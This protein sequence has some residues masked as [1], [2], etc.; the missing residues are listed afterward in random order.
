[1]RFGEVRPTPVRSA[2]RPHNN[3]QGTGA[4]DCL[5]FSRRSFACEPYAVARFPRSSLVLL[6]SP[7]SPGQQ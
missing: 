3:T 5:L 6:L 4:W 2:R 7:H 1:M